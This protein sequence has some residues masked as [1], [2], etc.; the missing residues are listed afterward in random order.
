MNK[1]DFNGINDACWIINIDIP[2]DSLVEKTINYIKQRINQT[3][4]KPSTTDA[5]REYL[6][7]RFYIATTQD[8]LR[9]TITEIKAHGAYPCVILAF[10]SYLNQHE[11][12][13]L[14]VICF[15]YISWT[16]KAWAK[17]K[18]EM[19]TANLMKLLKCLGRNLVDVACQTFFSMIF[20][21]YNG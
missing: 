12:D 9:D 17:A 2:D 8:S 3:L 19:T 16:N 21:Q 6:T 20:S 18:N 13:Q 5:H 1:P 15:K 14:G 7:E 10:N 11:C 4:L